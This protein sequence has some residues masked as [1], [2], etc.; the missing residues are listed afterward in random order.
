MAFYAV[1]ILEAHPSDVWQMQ[2]NVKDKVVF[3]SPRDFD[4]P[5]SLWTLDLAAAVAYEQGLTA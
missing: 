2:S 1:Y 4:K 3:R 5:T